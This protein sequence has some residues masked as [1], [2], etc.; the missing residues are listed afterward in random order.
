MERVGDVRMIGILLEEIEKRPS[1]GDHVAATMLLQRRLVDLIGGRRREGRDGTR[2]IRG[3]ARDR[4]SILGLG[5][6]IELGLQLRESA[7]TLTGRLLDRQQLPEHV[8]HVV[9]ELELEEANRLATLVQRIDHLLLEPN[10]PPQLGPP[11]GILAGVLRSEDVDL[12]LDL[13]HHAWRGAPEGAEQ[14]GSEQRPSTHRGLTSRSPP[15]V[16]SNSSRRFLANASS[17]RPLSA[18]RSSP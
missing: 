7:L 18:G 6:S 14:G 5:P 15:P 12:G 16:T 9:A 11:S 1:R 10:D 4:P 13:P 3:L 8:G 2:A 17:V